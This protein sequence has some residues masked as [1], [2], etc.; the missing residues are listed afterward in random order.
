MRPAKEYY[1]NA[2]DSGVHSEGPVDNRQGQPPT[3]GQTVPT[4]P[5]TAPTTR[6]AQ[7]QTAD[8][9]HNQQRH[10][11]SSYVDRSADCSVDRSVEDRTNSQAEVAEQ[12]R[13]AE[14]HR[15]HQPV[16]TTTYE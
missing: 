1:P 14:Y 9:E 3:T 5:A 6:P 4:G 8:D 7:A 13:R 12:V 11:S 15:A 10:R 16:P 2:T